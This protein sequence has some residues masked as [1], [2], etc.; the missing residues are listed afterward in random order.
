MW[1]AVMHAQ[2]YF[3]DR[4]R[5]KRSFLDQKLAFNDEE[6][7]KLADIAKLKTLRP[8]KPLYKEGD[9]PDHIYFVFEGSCELLKDDKILAIIEKGESLGEFPFLHESS[10]YTVTVI[11]KENSVIAEVSYSD[12]SKAIGAN[13]LADIQLMMSRTLARRLGRSNV[14]R[15]A[16]ADTVQKTIKPTLIDVMIG[17]VISCAVTIFICWIAAR[18]LQMEFFEELPDWLTGAYGYFTALGTGS[19]GLGAAVIHSLLRTGPTPDYF[20]LIGYCLGGI[21]LMIAVA[22]TG[23]I[24]ISRFYGS[25]L[26]VRSAYG[27]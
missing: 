2:G 27:L 10:T 15:L 7:G 17:W 1:G 6:A 8:K 12:F 18:F 26:A 21:F 25:G 20:R 3:E 16:D 5:R 13:R 24:L 11:A 22:I 4:E 19:V 14:S 23:A 9:T